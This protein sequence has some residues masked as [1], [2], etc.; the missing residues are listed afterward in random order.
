MTRVSN[1]SIAQFLLLLGIVYFFTAKGLVEISDTD[2]SLKTAQA[3]IENQTFLIDPPDPA[4]AASAPK[5]VEGKIYSK[6]GVGLVLIFLP[7]VLVAKGLAVLPG[8]QEVHVTG[9]LV[10]FYNIPFAL[11]A[12]YFFYR[13]CRQLG[14]SKRSAGLVILGMGVGTFFWKYTVTDYSE[15]TQVFFL[16]GTIYFL[17]R[18]KDQDMVKASVFFSGLLLMK[19]VNV[20][21]WGPLAIYVVLRYGLGKPGLLKLSKFASVVFLTGVALLLYNY[22][23]F[24]SPLSTG[25]ESEGPMFSLTNFRRDFWDFFFSPQRGLFFFNP[26]LLLAVPFWPAFFR[27]FPKEA[28]C[29]LIMITMWFCLMASWASY[30]GGWAWGNRLLI[31]TIPLVL[32]PL[33]LTPLTKPW[34][35]ALFSGLLLVSVYIQMVAV[36][37][38]THEYFV[39]LR[40]M[41]ADEDVAEYLGGMPPQLEGNAV[42]FHQKLEGKSGEY[43]YHVFLGDTLPAG[44][45]NKTISTLQYDSYQGLHV[46]PFHLATFLRQPMLRWLLLGILPCL[47]LIFFQMYKLAWHPEHMGSADR[48][49]LD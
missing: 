15:V 16:L 8:I 22:L 13:I 21:L 9:F 17:F 39:I 3:L 44:L 4:V 36:F 23:R 5:V 30:Q 6:Y 10:S 26:V 42:L 28:L 41:G 1:A 27:K 14:A 32:L 19:L 7:I 47:A 34:Q 33:A 12:L 49:I 11:G 18:S 29:L 31:I 37:Q 45:G 46:W 20:L 35:L 48:H 43:P 25:Y 24:G 38:H 2:Y 40:D